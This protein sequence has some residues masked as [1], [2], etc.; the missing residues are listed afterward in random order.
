[1]NLPAIIKGRVKTLLSRMGLEVHRL[2]LESNAALQAR[3]GLDRFNVNLVFDVGANVGQ[4]ASGLR[5]VGYNGGL[6]SFEPLSAAHRILSEV[7][8]G[9]RMW[10]IHPRSAIG[11]QD[12]EIEINIARNSVSSSLLPM[13]DAHRAAS[14]SSINV[15][16]ERAPICRLDS[17]A[18]NYLTTSSRAVL[19]IDAQGFE[20]EVLDGASNTLPRLQGVLCEL[21]LVPLYERQRLWL[22]VVRRLESEGFTLWS[23]RQ[24]FIDPRDGR[25]LQLDATFF[26]L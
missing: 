2:S 21:S 24:G 7:A 5:S 26:R 1:M 15:G 23:V 19:K 3:K 12:G 10:H 25:T 4:F 14:K 16:A 9:D 11:N 20:W 8:R 22:E 13:T 18:P 17:I 6:V